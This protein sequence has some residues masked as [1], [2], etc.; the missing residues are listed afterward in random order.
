MNSSMCQTIKNT[1]GSASARLFSLDMLRGLDM[2]LLT[3][4]GPLV[5]GIDKS[6]KLP[7]A[8][9]GQFRH[10]WE[11]F[12]FWDIIMPL[13]IFMC[14]AAI[15]L[16]LPKRL[17]DGKAGWAY[18]RHVLGRV[19]LLWF[20]G[21]LVQGNFCSLDPLKISIFSNT[22]QSI[23]VGYLATVA[24]MLVPCRCARVAI[25]ASLA[26]VYGLLIH[27]GGN[28]TWGNYTPQGN[29]T[30]VF[31][32]VLFS[33]FLPANNQVF[34]YLSNPNATTIY[35][36]VLPSMMFAFMTLCGF[37]A[38]EILKSGLGEWQKAGALAVY[39]GAMEAAGWILSI[40]VP[41]IKPIYTVSFT[42][43]AMGWC[44]LALAFLYAVTDIWRL[45]RGTWL[46]ILFGQF[47]L[48]AYLVTHQP[49]APALQALAKTLAQGMPRLF[50]ET[51]HPFVVQVVASVCL[52][53]ALVLRRALKARK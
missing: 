12:T 29:F 41:V 7:P 13:F 14:G 15:P 5:Y 35:T 32:R 50:G 51:A 16:A 9:M 37:H 36:W 23:A 25:T 10:G 46:V 38:T 40:W 33:W 26:V 30:V 39:G 52:V 4:V 43:Q 11:C 49:F 18:W 1:E 28:Y 31:D 47:A 34:A 44:V 48:T 24:V 42:L 45:R 20:C 3:V 2:L 27:F 19:A 22:L 21:M 53:F 6:W 8:V 17:V